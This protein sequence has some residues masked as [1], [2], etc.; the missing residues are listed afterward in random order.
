MPFLTD[1][2]INDDGF[3]RWRLVSTLVYEDWRGKLWY[4]PSGFRYDFASVPRVL[5]SIYPP[6]IAVKA[7]CVH[8]WC[9]RTKPAGVSRKEADRL[10][11][12]GCIDEGLPRVR[13]KVIWAA[14][15]LGGGFSWRDKI[16]STY[17]EKL[18]R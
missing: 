11:Y 9:Y 14:V 12:E 18:W 16:R 13:A 17:K 8:D 15:R 3:N 4:V 1:P 5:W 7:S 6:Q 2:D 10:L